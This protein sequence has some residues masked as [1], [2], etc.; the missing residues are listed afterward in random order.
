MTFKKFTFVISFWAILMGISMF[1]FFWSMGV[2][3][4]KFTVY[5]FAFL[6]LLI[7]LI[8]IRLTIKNNRQIN[9]FL[10]NY[11]VNE[12]SPKFNAPYSDSSFKLIEENLNRISRLYGKVKTEKEANHLFLQ[13]LID[14]IR[15][16]ILVYDES[17]SVSLHNKSVLQ[18][19]NIKHIRHIEEVKSRNDE[20][21]QLM[22]SN[23]DKSPV[24]IRFVG[25]EERIILSISVSQFIIQESSFYLALFKDVTNEMGQEEVESWQKLIKIMRHEIINSLTPITTLTSTLLDHLDEID[26]KKIIKGHP[27]KVIEASYKGLAAIEK[28]SKGLIAFMKGYKELSDTIKPKQ[29]EV[30]IETLF[31]QL[32]DLVS[33]DLIKKNIELVLK[34]QN[35]ADT[36]YIDEKQIVQVLLNLVKNAVEALV[37]TEN[38][39]IM[40]SSR[41]MGNLDLIEVIDNGIG[42]ESSEIEKIFIPFYSTKKEG[43]GIGLSLSKQIM[44]LH[45]GEIKVLSREN[46]TVFR[47]E[48]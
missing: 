33:A 21:Y 39:R 42:I 43:S 34:Y 45:K 48:F 26:Y 29:S 14:E 10:E 28:R 24:L 9:R 3:Y 16:G 37:N 11:I 27:L 25:K 44:H 15:V 40:I 2:E 4:L 18:M 1:L 7:L 32:S 12:G 19:L 36:L 22:K 8:I 23:I 13:Q 31:N 17:G 41:K 35:K 30:K 6:T 47:L 20:V 46:E 38:P 5:G